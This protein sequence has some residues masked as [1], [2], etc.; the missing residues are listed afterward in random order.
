MQFEH[1]AF[2]LIE[3]SLVEY[4]AV[5]F[6]PSLL[7][8]SAIYLARCT[9]QMTP[10]WTPLLGKHA[11]YEE[12]Q[13]RY[14]LLHCFGRMNFGGNLFYYIRGYHA[15]RLKLELNTTNL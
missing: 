13:M 5:D 7:C 8:A 12:S 4:E 10:A 3:L 6:K 11:Q 2:Y 14:L 15:C 9:L 1:L